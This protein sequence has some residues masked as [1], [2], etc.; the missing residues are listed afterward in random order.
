[1]GERLE[2]LRGGVHFAFAWLAFHPD[3]KIYATE[4]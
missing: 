1:M 3:S 4:H 2:P